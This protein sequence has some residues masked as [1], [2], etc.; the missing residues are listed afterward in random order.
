MACCGLGCCHPTIWM[1]YC[2]PMILLGQVMHRLKLTWSG[3]EADNAAESGST[4]RIMFWFGVFWV[5]LRLYQYVLPM[6]LADE[7]GELDENASM[8]SFV[9]N[10]LLM[11]I[12][13]FYL[14]IMCKVRRYIRGKYQIP[15]QQCH[16]CVSSETVSLLW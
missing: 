5:T 9:F 12:F 3:R 1:A 13:V 2:C 6:A 10:V 7:N 16:G 15:E 14:L 8:I 4:F 11:S